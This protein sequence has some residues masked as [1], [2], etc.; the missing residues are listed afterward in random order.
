MPSPDGFKELRYGFEEFLKVFKFFEDKHCT[1]TAKNPTLN[2]TKFLSCPVRSL[3]QQLEQIFR[4]DFILRKFKLVSQTRH[5][6]FR[7]SSFIFGGLRVDFF[8]VP[9][10]L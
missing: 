10:S 7:F 9:S 6:S 5:A 8:I 1:Q 3:Q 4:L 2:Q